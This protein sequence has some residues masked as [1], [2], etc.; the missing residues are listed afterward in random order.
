MQFIPMQMKMKLCAERNFFYVKEK[1]KFYSKF[2]KDLPIL[3]AQ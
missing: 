3:N 1:P 2:P